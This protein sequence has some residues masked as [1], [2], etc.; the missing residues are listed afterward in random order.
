[1]KYLYF[2]EIRIQISFLPHFLVFILNQRN[3]AQV[4]D[5]SL[6]STS[7]CSPS[8]FSGK[9]RVHENPQSYINPISHL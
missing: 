9:G 7:K 6:V 4:I 2:E 8:H 5:G 3:P 1:M